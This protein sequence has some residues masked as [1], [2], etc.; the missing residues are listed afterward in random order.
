MIQGGPLLLTLLIF[1]TALPYPLITVFV[2]IR[3][4]IMEEIKLTN[5]TNMTNVINESPI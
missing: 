4:I 5:M 3:I 1:D 2:A